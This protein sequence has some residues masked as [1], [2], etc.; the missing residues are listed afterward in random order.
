[1][2]G[3]GSA[4]VG[5]GGGGLGGPSFVWVFG[6]FFFLSGDAETPNRQFLFVTPPPKNK[7][8]YF[9]FILKK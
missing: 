2:R 3:D 9:F 7:Q 5:R 4:A 1:A 8:K 6:V